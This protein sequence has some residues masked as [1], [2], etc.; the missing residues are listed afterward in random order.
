[1]IVVWR[2]LVGGCCVLL[3]GWLLFDVIFWMCCLCLIC[4]FDFYIDEFVVLFYCL[5]WGLWVGG[6]GCFCCCGYLGLFDGL[7][8]GECVAY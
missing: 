3:V 1:M 8:L 6:F 5:V 7:G 2:C 4:L